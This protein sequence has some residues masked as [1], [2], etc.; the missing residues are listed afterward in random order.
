MLILEIFFLVVVFL[1]LSWLVGEEW[2]FLVGAVVGGAI[3]GALLYVQVNVAS[4]FTFLLYAVPL[5]LIIGGLWSVTKWY[6]YVRKAK[7]LYDEYGP[8]DTVVS[9]YLN[10]GYAFKKNSNEVSID[11]IRPHASH[12]KSRIVGWISLWPFSITQTLLRDVF[13]MIYDFFS[14][15]YDRISRRAFGG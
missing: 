11:S 13:T 9:P 7:R 5:Y 10:R 14:G 8:N 2:F 15:T 1:V 6:T 4:I 12:N 3:F